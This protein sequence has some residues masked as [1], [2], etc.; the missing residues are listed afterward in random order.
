MTVSL[1]VAVAENGVIGRND[2]VIPWKIPADLK[3]FKDVTMGHPII[4][5]RTTYESI[6]RALPGRRN[7]IISRNTTYLAEGC[8]VVFSLDKAIELAAS[9]D[10]NVFVIGGGSV[11][12][13]AL[14]KADSIYLTLVHA[15]P[16][17]EVRFAYDPTEWKEVSRQDHEA[18]DRNQYAYSFMKLIR[19]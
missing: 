5:G 9:E 15:E 19:K 17:G 8:E 18:D 10:K 11:Y 12:E 3:H 4:M 16:E 13:Q 6:G 1:V 14:P 7:I 2:G